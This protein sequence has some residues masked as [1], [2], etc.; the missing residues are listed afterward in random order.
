M[1]SPLSMLYPCNAQWNH[2]LLTTEHATM[3]HAHRYRSQPFVPSC[4]LVAGNVAGGWPGQ[5]TYACEPDA[6]RVDG[7][8]DDAQTRL[9]GRDA[10]RSKRRVPD[11]RVPR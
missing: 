8:S 4:D 9:E 10:G 6:E 1:V 7:P 11:H 5:E 3:G 2:V